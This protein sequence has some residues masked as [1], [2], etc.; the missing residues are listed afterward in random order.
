MDTTEIKNL[1]QFLG[2]RG[3]G[4]FS[5][6]SYRLYAHMRKFPEFYIVTGA[7]T[8]TSLAVGA[9]LLTRKAYIAVSLSKFSEIADMTD[10]ILIQKFGRDTEALG[11]AKLC[12]NEAL[13]LKTR[14]EI[15]QLRFPRL[16]EIASPGAMKDWILSRAE[17]RKTGRLLARSA[18]NVN[19][20]NL[21]DI[22]TTL[23]REPPDIHVLIDLAED[24]G[25]D[26]PTIRSALQKSGFTVEQVADAVKTRGIE[27]FTG[28][29]QE[30]MEKIK[31]MEGLVDEPAKRR[32]A[33]ALIEEA[34]DE[35][36]DDFN[37]FATEF[38]D[39]RRTLAKNLAEP[40]AELSEAFL[41]AM[42][43]AHVQ[44]KLSQ[45]V[46]IFFDAP[47][48]NEERKHAGRFIRLGLARKS[49]VL[50]VPRTIGE[51]NARMKGTVSS[52]ET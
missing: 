7:V 38:P 40:G 45:K 41:E 15:S 42:E 35:F 50:K 43:K 27:Q 36:R 52:D 44:K 8:G 2:E 14:Y 26:L 51:L 10:D 9:G 24:V 12:R 13:A 21:G 31:R 5:R 48:T 37:A 4:E 6:W 18:E 34:A 3:L 11:R 19:T 16:R 1:A 17:R 49:D 22:F 20:Q 23:K 29:A 47:I 33:L 32:R 28:R 46:G 30:I 39:A 25:E